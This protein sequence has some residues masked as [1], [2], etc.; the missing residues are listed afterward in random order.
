[1]HVSAARR[2]G[3]PESRLWAPDLSSGVQ[4]LAAHGEVDLSY[5]PT[6]IVAPS[7][8]AVANEPKG[9]AVVATTNIFL[10]VGHFFR[11]DTP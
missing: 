3:K 6:T 11:N 2:S 7:E 9:S 1:V 5:N 4:G 10:V 8:F